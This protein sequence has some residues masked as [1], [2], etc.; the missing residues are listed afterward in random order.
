MDSIEV[1][2]SSSINKYS[3]IKTKTGLYR[4]GAPEFVLKKD[5]YNKV[6]ES[7]EKRARKGKRV[8][9]FYK[10]QLPQYRAVTFQKFS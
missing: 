6:K 8:I 4:L 3:G 9:V 5:T 1:V 2:P 10:N 7:I